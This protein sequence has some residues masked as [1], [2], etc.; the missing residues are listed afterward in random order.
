MISIFQHCGAGAGSCHI[1]LEPL[2][3]LKNGSGLAKKR[4][5][6]NY[7]LETNSVVSF[8]NAHFKFVKSIFIKT[9]TFKT[10]KCQK[11]V[12]FFLILGL[13]L[14]QIRSRYFHRRLRGAEAAPKSNGSASL[15]KK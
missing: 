5:F 14:S 11:Y 4:F 7:Y 1:L 6:I 3:L 13:S 12:E 2:F 8:A 9:S 15:L 10:F